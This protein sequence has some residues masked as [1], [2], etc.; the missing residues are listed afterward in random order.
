MTDLSTLAASLSEAQRRAVLWC[1][2]DGSAR[3]HDKGAPR[4]V[5]FGCLA[6][7]I[8]GDP[9]KEVATICSIV[10]QANHPTVKSGLWPARTWSLTPL[11]R[12]LRDHLE[13][14]G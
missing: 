4:E 10:T 2:Q 8:D 6:K 14:N 9:T 12:Q 11:G 13:R 3:I 1:A 7:I 5:S